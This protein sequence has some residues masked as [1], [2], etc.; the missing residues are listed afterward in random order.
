MSITSSLLFLVLPR[1]WHGENDG[2]TFIN[3]KNLIL[4]IILEMNFPLFVLA[5]PQVWGRI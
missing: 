4:N 5:A 1:L 2:N 3:F